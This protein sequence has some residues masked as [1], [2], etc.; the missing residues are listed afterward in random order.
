MLPTAT[1]DLDKLNAMNAD[2]ECVAADIRH[3]E[4]LPLDKGSV[5]VKLMSGVLELTPISLGVAGGTMAG[6]IHIDS[7]IKPAA[8]STQ[9]DL[10]G[11]QFN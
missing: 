3:I 8:F 6:S 2:V 5:H 11:M 7:T 1:L 10:R 4:V 9:L